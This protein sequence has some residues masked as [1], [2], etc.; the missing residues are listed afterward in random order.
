[1]DSKANLLSTYGIRSNNSRVTPG[2]RS[3]RIVVSRAEIIHS[4]QVRNPD[5]SVK[6]L[7]GVADSFYIQRGSTSVQL[8]IPRSNTRFSE[9]L[10][11]SASVV[12]IELDLAS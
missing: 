6:G 3:I 7:E 4:R 11:L 12:L 1:L 9:P 10:P 8:W 2:V 5:E